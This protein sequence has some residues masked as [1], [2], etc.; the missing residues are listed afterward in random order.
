MARYPIGTKVRILNY[1]TF[2]DTNK[3][4]TIVEDYGTFYGFCNMYCAGNGPETLIV[5]K[6]TTI[7]YE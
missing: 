7:L 4:Y 6:I 2:F 1:E 3:T 5:S